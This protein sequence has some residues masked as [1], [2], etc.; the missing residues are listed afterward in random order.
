MGLLHGAYCVGC[1]WL[2]MGL[3]F[4]AG[5]MNLW[6]VSAIAAFVLIEKVAVAGPWIARATGALLILWGGWTL[7]RAV[8]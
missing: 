7:A 8:G 3:L 6:W 5:V 4:V 2:L 1:C